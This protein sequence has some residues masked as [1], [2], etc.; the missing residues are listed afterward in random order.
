MPDLFSFPFRWVIILT[1]VYLAFSVVVAIARERESGAMEL[2]FYGPVDNVSY[3]LGK[4]SAQLTV[5]CSL[6]ILYLICFFILSNIAGV[7]IP[8]SFYMMMLLSLVTGAYLI[9]VGVFVSTMSRNVRSATLVFLTLIA[10][11]LLIQASQA[12]LSNIAPE[13]DYYNPVLLLQQLLGWI[14]VVLT[15]LSPFSYLNYGVSEMLRG[16][17]S[18][19]LRV[20]GLSF[21]F[22]ITFVFSSIIGL[23]IRGVRQ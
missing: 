22:C 6:I 10:S 4:Y 20:V 1:S 8:G 2:L 14:Q 5:Y 13:S 19:F 3:V 18:A 21:V 12:W 11:T 16:N 23:K 7:Q 17:M 9:S 15:W